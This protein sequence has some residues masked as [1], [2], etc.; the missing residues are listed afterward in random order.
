M[1]ATCGLAIDV[2]D[3]GATLSARE[4]ALHLH[5][6]GIDRD[7]AADRREQRLASG[8]VHRTDRQQSSAR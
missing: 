8:P 4:E 1:P 2:P 3:K 7:R 6:I 5:A